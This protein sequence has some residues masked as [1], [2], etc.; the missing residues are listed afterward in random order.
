VLRKNEREKTCS[1]QKRADRHD[2]MAAI[3]I[4]EHP[5]TRREQP[6]GEQR[7]RE[8]SH[9]ERD[10]PTPLAR[11]QRNGEHRWIEQ[12]SPGEDLRHPED[13]HGPPGSGDDIT[14][15]GHDLR[16]PSTGDARNCDPG[17]AAGRRCGQGLGLL[18]HHRS[19]G[20]AEAAEMGA[21]P[22]RFRNIAAG[23]DGIA[24][25][26]EE[27]CFGRRHEINGP[28]FQRARLAFERRDNG[29][30]DPHSAQLRQCHNG[31]QKRVAAMNLQ[32]AEA[33]GN[34]GARLEPPEQGS[35]LGDIVGR[36]ARF[37]ERDFE[38]FPLPARERRCDQAVGRGH[39]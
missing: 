13:E 18:D 38:T 33:G 19:V 24:Q 39:L 5:D 10:R 22:Y 9:C 6:C 28:T 37:D 27:M 26:A 30:A 25:A 20:A 23:A 17:K 12:C 1:T 16:D 32:P 3:S 29:P 21:F 34:I 14:G 15:S 4:Y 2:A 31:S 8:S 11:N 36:Q 35:R 7:E